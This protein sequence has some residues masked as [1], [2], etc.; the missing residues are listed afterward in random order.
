MAEI[1]E[2]RTKK[3]EDCYYTFK[4][5]FDDWV[6]EGGTFELIVVLI[7]LVLLG[8][9]QVGDFEIRGLCSNDG[10]FGLNGFWFLLENVCILATTLI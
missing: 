9:E 1:F 6:F 2:I 3:D 7:V 8:C 4:L 5:A 10:N